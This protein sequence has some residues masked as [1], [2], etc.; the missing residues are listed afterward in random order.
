MDM[1]DDDDASTKRVGFSSDG[2]R[3]TPKL[4]LLAHFCI[5]DNEKE[6]IIMHAH[7]LLPPP[8]VSFLAQSSLGPTTF[9]RSQ[10]G[11]KKTKKNQFVCSYH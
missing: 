9:Q 8:S 6:K 5:P 11:N 3:E 2:S 7:F 1:D 4:K 10:S